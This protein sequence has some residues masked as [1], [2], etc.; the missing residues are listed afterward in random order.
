YMPVTR[1]T[2]ASGKGDLVSLQQDISTRKWKREVR[3]MAHEDERRSED[4]EERFLRLEEDVAHISHSMDE[5][6]K[7]MKVVMENLGVSMDTSEASEELESSHHE[8]EQ[9]HSNQAPPPFKAEEKIDIQPYEGEVNADKLDHWLSIRYT[10][11]CIQ[12]N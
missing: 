7:I 12:L 8:K 10:F 2:S 11:I 4:G 5:L 6:G 1:A 9:P 3:S